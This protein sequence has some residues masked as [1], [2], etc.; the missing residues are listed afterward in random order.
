MK[1]TE[2]L[3]VAD[4]VRLGKGLPGTKSRL[5]LLA[6]ADES[7]FLDPPAAEIPKLPTPDRTAQI[8]LINKAL[9]NVIQTFK[10]LPNFFATRTT[11]WFA[12]TPTTVSA[13]LHNELFKFAVTPP[14]GDDRLA[15]AGTTSATVAYRD[16]REVYADSSK[17]K[18]DEFSHQCE[19]NSIGEFGEVLARVALAATQ[20]TV[21]WS[22]WERGR[23]GPLAVFQCAGRLWSEGLTRCPSQIPGMPLIPLP[24]SFDSRGE[25]AVNAANGTIMRVTEMWRIEWTPWDWEPSRRRSAQCWNMALWRSEERHTCA[26]REAYRLLFSLQWLLRAGCSASDRNLDF[27]KM[28]FGSS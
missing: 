25:I 18:M 22:H 21:T 4:E 10:Q 16:G 20:G 3:S 1:L 8:A 23:D 26:R 9:E 28:P 6:I 27:Q 15:G 17:A 12:G 24:T 2:R 7:A 19:L 14:R 11:V 5:A 13:A